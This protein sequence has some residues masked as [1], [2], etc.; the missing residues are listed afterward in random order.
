MDK[1][2][3]LTPVVHSLYI[4]LRGSSSMSLDLN[5]KGSI[6]DPSVVGPTCVKL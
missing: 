1:S 2:P 6:G 5:D 4:L 3:K